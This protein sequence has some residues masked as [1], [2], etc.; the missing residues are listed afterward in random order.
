MTPSFSS[1]IAR[2]AQCTYTIMGRKEPRNLEDILTGGSVM[3]LLGV[4]LLVA[5]ELLDKEVIK[6]ERA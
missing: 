3:I 6:V 5:F 2:D 4:I 1:K